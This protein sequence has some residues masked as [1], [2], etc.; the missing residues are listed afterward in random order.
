MKMDEDGKAIAANIQCLKAALVNHVS[1]PEHA[2]DLAFDLA[3]LYSELDEV[4]KLLDGV[5]KTREISRDDLL[6]ISTLIGY[7][8]YNHI[9]SLRKNLK[10][11]ELLF[12]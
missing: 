10:G 8:W 11:E 6:K 5:L 1:N 9:N 3:E 12:P 4:K 2:S 7:H